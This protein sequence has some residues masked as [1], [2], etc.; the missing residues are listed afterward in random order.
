MTKQLPMVI[1]LILFLTS[2]AYAQESTPSPSPAPK[3][4]M[5]RAQSQRMI[6]ATEKKLWE[7]WKNKDFKPFKA[8]LSADS[9]MIGDMGTANKATAIKDLESLACE[10]KSYE[11]S[12]IK[13]TF[14]NSS[15]A[16]MTYKS[17]Q[18]ATCGGQQVPAAVWASSAYVMRGG[19][20]LA[21]SH[22]ETPAK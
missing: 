1:V 17:T 4:A 13:V 9:I 14:L 6:I 5:S 18:D 20:W 12:D 2:L 10:V 16:L 8:N 19:K 21:A 7:A 22:Q 3:P 15:A 11:M